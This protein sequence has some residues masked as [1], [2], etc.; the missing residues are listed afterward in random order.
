MIHYSKLQLL[1]TYLLAELEPRGVDASGIA[2]INDPAAAPSTVF[3]K[4]LRSSR[5]VVRPR[6][7]EVI[8]TIGPETNFILLHA[9]ATT[10]GNTTN[11]FNN[12]PII[13]PG[14][15]GIHNGT[16]T[17][18][19]KLFKEYED[20]FPRLGEVDSAV[21]FQLYKHFAD[22]GK[23]PTAALQETAR[24]LMG[25]FTGALV[26]GNHPNRMV[27]FKHERPLCL[28]RI[29][30]YDIVVAVSEACFYTRAAEKAKVNPKSSYEYVQDGTGIIMDLNADRRIT[31]DIYNFPL[32]IEH[33]TKM[34]MKHSAW[35]NSYS[36]V[37]D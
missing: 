37:T 10:S 2:V 33:T 35:L 22:E 13:V 16:L 5:L 17:N 4:P 15:V 19:D 34:K 21:I 12:H 30:H 18:D 28:I 8:E 3:K 11:N 24:N 26:D 6:F 23:E 31:E 27:M 7:Q 20:R 14:C 25:A 1:T 36:E 32:P 9:R 29:P